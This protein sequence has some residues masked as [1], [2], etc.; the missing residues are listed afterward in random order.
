MDVEVFGHFFKVVGDLVVYIIFS[1]RIKIG[2]AVR[3]FI[4]FFYKLVHHLGVGMTVF[5]VCVVSGNLFPVFVVQDGGNICF[6]ILFAEVPAAAFVANFVRVGETQVFVSSGFH[7]GFKLCASHRIISPGHAHYQI[8]ILNQMPSAPEQII[9]RVR[10]KHHLVVPVQIKGIQVGSCYMG[11]I[12][13]RIKKIKFMS[14][15]GNRSQY[16]HRLIT[17]N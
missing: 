16:I 14:G 8:I 5:A 3:L 7:H 17:T 13:I 15:K 9:V 4:G 1:K 12:Q 10:H 2:I 11:Q 6:H